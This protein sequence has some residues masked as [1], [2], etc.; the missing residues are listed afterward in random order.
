MAIAMSAGCGYLEGADCDIV[1]GDV[2]HHYADFAITTIQLP[3]NKSQFAID[4]TGGGNAVSALGAIVSKLSAAGIDVQGAVTAALPTSSRTMLVAL[5]ST[6]ASFMSDVCAITTLESGASQ[7]GGGYKV[8][9]KLSSWMY[10]GPIVKGQFSS[11]APQLKTVA[12]KATLLLPLFPNSK[13]LEIP[14]TAGHLQLAAQKSGIMGAQLQGAI[15]GMDL[16]GTVIPALATQLTTAIQAAPQSMQAMQIAQLLDTGGTAD[17][18]GACGMTCRDSDGTCAKAG[19]GTIAACEIATN[20]TLMPLLAPD[21]AI[22]N[23][24]VFAPMP[25][26]AKDSLSFAIGFNATPATF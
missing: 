15:Q 7:A 4:L 14:F 1:A 3:T 8:D 19:D 9:S 23:N 13:P 22:F 2:T 11:T 5:S 21:V 25:T 24:G 12:S 26:G 6:D 20:P 16:T 10:N 17:A 18:S